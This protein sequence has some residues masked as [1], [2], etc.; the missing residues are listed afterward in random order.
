ML[1]LCGLCVLSIVAGSTCT[2]SAVSPSF[3]SRFGG[4]T[5]NITG[6]G[7][8]NLQPGS[9]ILCKWQNSLLLQ[10]NFVSS[11]LIQCPVPSI[12]RFVDL[13]A[14]SSL[15]LDSLS[16]SFS[17]F[18]EAK[19]A[20]LA[21]ST[22][23]SLRWRSLDDELARMSVWPHRT[24][25][26]YTGLL[27]Y[28][29][30]SNVPTEVTPI[31]RFTL[32]TP[33][34]RYGSSILVNG[35]SLNSTT[36]ECEAPTL[37]EID[38]SVS[39][40]FEALI[41]I[42]FDAGQTFSI[43]QTTLQYL[44][45]IV[46]TSTSPVEI[47]DGGGTKV[48]LLGSGFLNTTS[49]SCIFEQSS[50]G[51]Q[52]KAHSI[53][54]VNESSIVCQVPFTDTSHGEL[55]PPGAYDILIT[56]DGIHYV[57]TGAQVVTI[58]TPA[59]T[60]VFPLRGYFHGGTLVNVT[61]INIRNDSEFTQCVFGNAP[62]RMFVYI[63]A[64]L[65][66]CL[67]PACAQAV[68]NFPALA[69]P[70][71]CFGKVEVSVIYT[72]SGFGG[73]GSASQ[74]TTNYAQFEY[75]AAQKILGF[76]PWYA[77]SWESLFPVRLI[78]SGFSAPM[79]CRWLDLP[80]FLAE[81]VT[82]T[83]ADCIAP[84]LPE[85]YRPTTASGLDF[86][87]A[88]VEVS[89]NDQD[90]TIDRRQ[91][92]FVAPP[93]VTSVTPNQVW[94]G[95]I[96]TGGIFVYGINFRAINTDALACL[97]F[98]DSVEVVPAVFIDKNTLFCS[99]S[100]P[101]SVNA[102][103]IKI[104]VRMA[105][106][107]E[108]DSGVSLEVTPTPTVSAV[109]PSA[110]GPYL[111]GGLWNIT[112]TN[113]DTSNA[114][115]VI[116]DSAVSLGDTG[117]GIRVPPAPHEDISSTK[118]VVLVVNK[119]DRLLIGTYTYHPVFAG[120]L[121]RPMIDQGIPKLCPNG[122][123]CV[124]MYPSNNSLSFTSGLEGQACPP[125][126]FQ[127][128]LSSS[129]CSVCASPSY[130]PRSGQELPA[131]CPPGK[132]CWD[133]S[134][135]DAEV[136]FCPMGRMC[137]VPLS[138]AIPS[139]IP[140]VD[141]PFR[142]LSL[143]V[144]DTIACPAGLVCPPGSVPIS[145][146]QS[147][148]YCSD[149]T[150]SPYVYDIPVP[151]GQYISPDGSALLP[152]PAGYACDGASG[153]VRACPPGSYSNTAESDTCS[154]C[155]AGTMCPSTGLVLPEQCP[156]GFVCSL[157]GRIKP[158]FMCPAG[159]YC[160]ENTISLHSVGGSLI[161]YSP[162]LCP[163]G[164]YCSPGTSQVAVDIS[165]PT[166]PRLCASGFFCGEGSVDFQ[167]SG[168]CPKGFFCE[169][170]STVPA[171]APPGTYV[172]F[173]GAYEAIPCPPGSYQDE[174][175][176]ESCKICP[177]G[178]ECPS[179]G[180]KTA[181]P[182]PP[183][184]Y[185]SNSDT[186]FSGSENVVCHP[187]PEGTWNWRGQLVSSAECLT[188][189]ER[190]V[191]GRQGMTLFAT[192]DETDCSSN[193]QFGGASICYALTQGSDCPEGYACDAGTT[194]FTQ[195]S[196]P[197]D[198]G[199]FCKPLTALGE[200][201]NLLCPRGYVC[202][203]ATGYSKAYT[204][205]CPEGY[206]C[207]EGTAGVDNP[208]GSLVLYNIQASYE[209]ISYRNPDTDAQCR[210]CD[211]NLFT[212]PLAIDAS[213][214]LP[215]G[216]ETG[217]IAAW[218]NLRCPD[219]TTSDRGSVDPSDCIPEGIV[220]AV[221]N[222]YNSSDP[223]LWRSDFEDEW[224]FDPSSPA[225]QSKISLQYGEPISSTNSYIV[226][227]LG[228]DPRKESLQFVSVPMMAL[229]ILRLDFDFSAVDSHVV[230]A[231]T[232]NKGAGSFVLD[233]SGSSALLPY[234]VTSSDGN[235]QK[236]FS[237][238]ILSL[239]DNLNINVSLSL[240]DG[241]HYEDMHS[242]NSSLSMSVGSP[243]R[244]LANSRNSFFSVIASDILNSG[245]YELPYNLIPTY[246]NQPGDISMTVDLADSTNYTVDAELSK[247]MIP[248]ST[249]W[250]VFGASTVGL[251]W[252]PFFSNCDYFDKHI[253][254]WDLLEGNTQV[255]P[256]AGACNIVTNLDDVAVVAP[257]IYDFN[258][259]KFQFQSN[260][261]WC[262]LA[263]TCRYEDNM[264]FGSGDPI[265][266]MA[267]PGSG[268]SPLFYLT[269]EALA[270]E[271]AGGFGFFDSLE[272]TDSL[273]P[274][275]LDATQRTGSFPRLIS[276]SIS[277]AQVTQSEK[278]IVQAS[279]TFTNFD[280]DAS[281]KDY[282]LQISFEPMN[283]VQMMNTFQLAW[284]VYVF[285]FGLTG[286]SVVGLGI[287]AWMALRLISSV[288]KK[289]RS[290]SGRVSKFQLWDCYSFFLGYS[291]QGVVVASVPFVFVT[292]F[293]KLI[294]L[295]DF[296]FLASLPCAF[297]R[298]S[299][300]TS[301]ALLTGIT[302]PAICAP[303][304]TGT[305]LIMSG[306]LTL[307][308]SSKYFAPR[309]PEEHKEYIETASSQQ[310]NDD[311]I[312]VEQKKE[313]IIER[314]VAWKRFHIFLTSVLI[315]LPLMV[316]FSFSYSAMFGNFTVYYS[317][318]YTLTMLMADLL[319]IKVAREKSTFNYLAVVTDVVFF[320][321]T[322]SASDLN[323][324]VLSYL[325]GTYFIVVQRLIAENVI[326]YIYEDAIPGFVRWIKTRQFIWSF[327]LN[328]RRFFSH[329][330]LFWKKSARSMTTQVKKNESP[331]EALE[332]SKVRQPIVIAKAVKQVGEL[333]DDIDQIAGVAS[334][335]VSLVFGPFAILL[336]RV[337]STET[338]FAQNYGLLLSSIPFYIMFSVIVI[339]CQIGLEI[340]I[341]H[342]FD[343]TRGTR[344]YDYMYLC[345]WR[346]RT[347]LTRWLLDD[348]RLDSSLGQSSQALHHLAF[349]PQFYFI[350]TYSVY[351]GVFVTY[352]LTCWI[353]NGV[354]GF[355]DP[356]TCLF[357]VLI[358]IAQR[359]ADAIGRWLVFHVLWA[360]A[361]RAPEKAFVQSV[362]LGLKQKE[363]EE[364]EV[365]FRNYFFQRHREWIIENLDKVYTP[366]GIAKYKSQLSEIYQKVLSIRIPYLYTA[367]VKKPTVFSIEHPTD[368][369]PE[370]LVEQPHSPAGGDE[371]VEVAL[372]DSDDNDDMML[373]NR[374]APITYYL[375]QGWL[376][377]ARRRVRRNRIQ[378]EGTTF[379]GPVMVTISDRSKAI[380][381]QWL[382]KV[383]T[384]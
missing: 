101:A 302:D 230:M 33:N 158:S 18:E 266:W 261:D 355:L 340:A 139:E 243:S 369:R 348:Q 69:D 248:G 64:S 346:W 185:R 384:N 147:G 233:V 226:D 244:S 125:G 364:H 344:L 193:A 103:R 318:G 112:T 234:T 227:F 67:S 274:V 182:C 24:F 152:C 31:C 80:S 382:K 308:T 140:P 240:L 238:K 246:A 293:V 265:P 12:Y 100:T 196:F 338:K 117:D 303:I 156:P 378:A 23:L 221:V 96:R 146:S 61:G 204:I 383:R 72:G 148:V 291:I 203:Q 279:I 280:D 316:M 77:S 208:D 29:N 315:C 381:M 324:F 50:S 181:F 264:E 310:L 336:I 229:D 42:S 110:T 235:W 11:S 37:A 228:F 113:L 116:G 285:V 200:M 372:D 331:I 15:T 6:V 367:P 108:S 304:R 3:V 255:P 66:Q 168:A 137:N 323:A 14:N 272:G 84:I 119:Q 311:G 292:G 55:L 142:Q 360:P 211:I 195:Y 115:I 294:N 129:G 376:E 191:C 89:C 374:N 187:C 141:D 22:G 39:A 59:A 197:C 104:E 180:L 286:C 260:S 174:Y 54:F 189:P 109:T 68:D 149:G 52:L 97:W 25:A 150:G 370:D 205:V 27:L 58:V 19:E 9:G 123:F 138:L 199:F 222:I 347:R 312:L 183:A 276:L 301:S 352:G 63:N 176:K 371:F 74:T 198:P 350:V 252:L 353:S 194:S 269:Q 167:G 236:K 351:G 46:V 225:Y 178:F 128:S 155:T 49:L 277:Y 283:W 95:S 365:A 83:S 134:G 333:D 8:P 38:P 159:S 186:I 10:G 21:P 121:Y 320:V 57:N 335:I 90:F 218:A 247:T 361:D 70:S 81:N 223:S 343:S 270:F 132:V 85:S 289:I 71:S 60:R 170:G 169:A 88:Y 73:L 86:L 373:L 105:P 34:G 7:F 172:N 154:P 217:P 219:G 356:A 130:C 173:E 363:L 262:E 51:T 267:M 339:P 290:R 114:Y 330:S 126:S 135:N 153:L 143:L 209:E 284:Y 56:V 45:D 241:G 44:P 47:L 328:A 131:W 188:C 256:E 91:W 5:L 377:A 259:G 254:L 78:G 163:E 36:I 122:F 106:N 263:V 41:H 87:L 93:V 349:S 107:V 287:F 20:V 337:F 314:M 165:N 48:T 299:S 98:S 26:S 171:P 278:R 120:T 319:F 16:V 251:P 306:V 92:L 184:E 124:G 305:C 164:T 207:P 99:P 257:L 206:F 332:Y 161:G 13:S 300:S 281:N 250:Q 258:T 145:C 380:M 28:V 327:F 118:N 288:W 354:A 32:I 175:G 239:Q 177:D 144:D 4:N 213:S 322:L 271:T 216:L 212:P 210:K 30:W 162:I 82:A 43:P 127:A 62:T 362:A 321:A 368:D 157:P 317:V 357:V 220:L 75:V 275:V 151:S 192:V 160:L 296:A 268:S 341:N 313:T 53:K 179:E 379:P 133:Q 273:I 309:L 325:F 375:V 298:G 253:V 2:F 329:L 231:T 111:G 224:V 232:G 245:G 342:G 242:F 359:F 17:P 1:A 297:E 214:C 366:R 249:F 202:K 345:V 136:S 65:I 40:P 358:L 334:R 201:R 295:P 215:C 35:V 307:W 237:L 326:G 102:S 190:Y 79:F 76:D 166:A 94:A 282:L